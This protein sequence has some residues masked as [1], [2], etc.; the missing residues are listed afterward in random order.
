MKLESRINRTYLQGFLKG[1]RNCICVGV[2]CEI[3]VEQSKSG[4]GESISSITCAL[5]INHTFNLFPNIIVPSW[6]GWSGISEHGTYKYGKAY[7]SNI[8]N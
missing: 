2:T 1:K 8:D 7:N 3:E 5:M 6:S 4:E